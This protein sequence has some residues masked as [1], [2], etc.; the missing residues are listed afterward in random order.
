MSVIQQCQLHLFNTLPHLP[1][2]PRLDLSYSVLVLLRN[3]HACSIV[4]ICKELGYKKESIMSCYSAYTVL[5]HYR[6]LLYSLQNPGSKAY[7]TACLTEEQNSL[8]NRYFCR[9][10]WVCAERAAWRTLQ[11]SQRTTLHPGLHHCNPKAAGPEL[12]KL[13][14]FILTQK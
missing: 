1:L 3:H 5:L 14:G 11:S 12:V 2:F 8:E 7:S 10:M 4:C 9:V 13:L 6:K